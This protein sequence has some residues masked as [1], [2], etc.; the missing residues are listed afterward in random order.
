MWKYVLAWIPMI[1][2]AVLNGALRQFGY[3]PLVGELAA[4]QLSTFTLILLFTAYFWP[5]LRRWPPSTG[6]QAVGVGLLWLA[7]TLGFE[8]GFFHYVAGHPWSRLLHEYDLPSG[9]VWVFVPLYVAV[10]PWLFRCILLKHPTG[11]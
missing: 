10:A 8:F 1:V 7:M 4:H 6:A 3:L 11:T 9:R 5:L 2:L